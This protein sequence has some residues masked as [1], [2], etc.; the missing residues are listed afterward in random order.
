MY[1]DID[2]PLLAYEAFNL[3]PETMNQK[4]IEEKLQETI[5]DFKSETS[6]RVEE[7]TQFS[8]IEEEISIKK[9]ERSLVAYMNM[10]ED[11][12]RGKSTRLA[13]YEVDKGEKNKIQLKQSDNLSILSLKEND[14]ESDSEDSEFYEIGGESLQSFK[15]INSDLNVSEKM[16]ESFL[17]LDSLNQGRSSKFEAIP[18]DL[19]S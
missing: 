12:L 9:I 3:C 18:G 16:S 8:T 5:Q 1:Q 15:I 10:L 13:D 11:T 14:G 6:T 2:L 19:E 4:S 17:L 7:E